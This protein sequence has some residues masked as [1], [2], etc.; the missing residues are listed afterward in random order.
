MASLFGNFRKTLRKAG[1]TA[2]RASRFSGHP[3]RRGGGGSQRPA[4]RRPASSGRSSQ[5]AKQW[6]DLILQSVGQVVDPLGNVMH[7]VK[8][9][10][11]EEKKD[12][13]ENDLR[14]RQPGR[15]HPTTE[16]GRNEQRTHIQYQPDSEAAI[17]ERQRAK[18]ERDRAQAE[19][20]AAR[21]KALELDEVDANRELGL[22]EVQ[23][24][25][26]PLTTEEYNKLTVRQRA[27]VDYNTLLVDAIT[28]DLKNQD[29]YA[30]LKGTKRE[31]RYNKTV[32]QLFGTDRGS[33]IFAPETVAVL[34]QI[35][36]NPAL[37]K[38]IGDKLADLDDYL[39]L[40]ATV[41]EADLAGLVGNAG[42]GRWSILNA[43]DRGR[44]EYVN[45]F[46]DTAERL[47][48]AMDN[49]RPL[50]QNLS[51]SAELARFGTE[52]DA[53][54]MGA[55]GTDPDGFLG[56][57]QPKF[58][59][60]PNTGEKVPANL[61]TYFQQAFENL[62]LEQNRGKEDDIIGAMNQILKP[63]EMDKFFQYADIRSRNLETYQLPT[64]R[65]EEGHKFKT[66]QEFRKILGLDRLK[67]E[68]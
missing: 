21:T 24:M 55:A 50:L 4:P 15:W 23:G 56:F 34:K 18:V 67:G 30:D 41:T 19:G 20:R 59:V 6:S 42:R 28:K 64:G 22:S 31:A 44:T 62:G 1:S 10:A 14:G 57:N 5:Q 32:K 46:A 11:E 9:M 25:T 60:D 58:E 16:R 8:P 65:T 35:A 49:S 47:A 51:E 36:Y 48:K 53:A 33:D 27:A 26:K 68:E 52:Y 37:D 7:K 13:L 3:T 40:K 45:Q 63:D 38:V 66:P 17:A 2:T 12:A 43:N 29:E 61:D 54:K 39:G